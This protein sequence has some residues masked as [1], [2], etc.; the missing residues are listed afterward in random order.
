ME[1]IGTNALIREKYNKAVE[2]E[3]AKIQK[4]KRLEEELREQQRKEEERRKN[5]FHK[6]TCKNC[7]CIFS[8]CEAEEYYGRWEPCDFH[9]GEERKVY[10]KCP[11]CEKR[12]YIR[13]EEI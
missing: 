12:I 5:T 11:H 1:I 2:K 9:G 3:E 6:L 13:T 7:G 4:E 8:Y 10:I